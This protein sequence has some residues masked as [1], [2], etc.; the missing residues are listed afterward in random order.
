MAHEALVANRVP[1]HNGGSLRA[2]H[3]QSIALVAATLCVANLGV[4][5]CAGEPNGSSTEATTVSSSTTTSST[6]ASTNVSSQTGTNS[7]VVT[8]TSTD[9]AESSD[10]E[11]SASGAE[12]VSPTSTTR[13]TTPPATDTSGPAT[14]EPVTTNPP[15]D[16]SVAT[17][18]VAGASGAET[19]EPRPPV[20]LP[21]GVANMFPLPDAARVCPDPS[22]H[23]W[24]EGKPTLGN[25]GKV[26]VY[27]AASPNAPVVTVDLA[28]SN[29]TDTLGGS[30]FKLAR[31][32]F[33]DENE[34]IITLPAAGLDYGRTYFV[35]ID[36]GVVTGPEG[37]FTISDDQTW[38][39]TTAS[40][41]PANTDELRVALDDSAQFCTLQNAVDAADDDTT[42]NIGPG[43]Y[44]GLVYFK[45][46]RGLTIHGSDRERTALKGINNNNLN[47][48]TRGRALIGSE[49]VT[50]LTIENLTIQN[51]TPQD[52]SQAEAL[53]LLSCDQCVVRD[54]NILSLQDTLLWSGRIYAEDCYIAGNVDYIWGTGTVYFNRCEIHTVGRK[55]Y[56]VQSRNGGNAHGYVFVDSKLTSDSGITGDVLARIDV[57]EYPNSEV[58]YIDCEMGPHISPA[59]WL[60]S[61][62]GAPQSLR[63]L[64]YRSR[65]PNG[66]L[67]NT[68][69]RLTGSRQL[70]ESDA[71]TYRDPSEILG[72]WSPP[73]RTPA[74]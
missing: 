49:S 30:N 4:A 63:F 64:E 13:P 36:A 41:P 53:A 19:S 15:E 27:D 61:G 57:A 6:S 74:N 39:F 9:G 5:G 29:L 24:F 25:Q 40:A 33:V 37:A 3:W 11:N 48:S 43:N 72:G 55:G 51:L 71:L 50:G 46:K 23:L 38:R 12:T 45:N 21:A 20:D 10:A 62:G 42:I 47:P 22:L 54:A 66:E 17:T 44:Y 70:N 59:G 69:Q 16:S 1:S 73:V 2:N 58:A 56:N 68:S 65:A 26:A 14:T 35:K 67:V 28:Q 32:A 52:G 8:P 31:R 7:P 60:I 34:V 18:D